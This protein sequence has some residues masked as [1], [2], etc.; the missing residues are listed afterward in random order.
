M[1]RTDRPELEWVVLTLGDRPEELRAAVES[2]SDAAV[3]VVS[4]G[5]GPV[6]VGLARTVVE[7]SNLGIPG[8]RDV[9]LRSS[10]AEIVAFLD[11]DAVA[12]PGVSDRI[13]ARF[14]DDPDV[15]AVA[16]RLVD[17]RGETARRHV[18]RAGRRGVDRPG[19][20]ALFLGGACA[21]RRTAYLGV[22]G[23]FLDLR[24]G[25]EELELAW[26]LIDAGW[27][28]RYEPEARVYHP[29][30]E[31]GRHPEGWRMTGRNRVLVARRTL[32]WAV[33]LVHVAAWLP[34][35][36]VRA[37]DRGNRRAYVRGWFDGWRPAV[38]RAPIRWRT[39]W[40]LTRLGRAPF[41]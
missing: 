14:A 39:V 21:I 16:L 25:H 40:R 37:G 18:P 6:D 8:G 10:E 4:N 3:C 5:G 7:P 36:L 1:N 41:V 33:A 17:D 2:L 24:Y 12:E 15:G 19:D 13:R 22:G 29:S 9:G 32:P 35:G 31:I 26:R 11:D 23:Y 27:R 28:I 38:D 30:T 34:L 20:V